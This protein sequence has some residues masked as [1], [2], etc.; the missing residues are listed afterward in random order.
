MKKPFSISDMLKA[1]WFIGYKYLKNITGV[2]TNFP[3]NKVLWTVPYNALLKCELIKVADFIGTRMM[4]R[5]D[6]LWPYLFIF[7]FD[8]VLAC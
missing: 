8:A 3:K 6:T 7:H 2:Y 5:S 4:V 1:Q